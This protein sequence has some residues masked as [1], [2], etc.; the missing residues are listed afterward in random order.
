[1]HV[2]TRAKRH[3]FGYDNV[4]D[5]KA[6]NTSITKS[7]E[8]TQVY[9]CNIPVRDSTTG[10]VTWSGKVLT[11]PRCRRLCETRGPT[12]FFCLRFRLTFGDTIHFLSA[13]LWQAEGALYAFPR[14]RLS[15][16]AND[17]AQGKGLPADEYYCLK[18]LWYSVEHLSL[19]MLVAV[20][21][22]SDHKP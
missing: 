13:T 7:T 15:K 3:E 1:M 8:V 20:D 16:K 11:Y 14:I 12:F 4:K 21:T 17:V 22:G 2:Q 5:P 10:K 19:R 9:L 18:V 6:S